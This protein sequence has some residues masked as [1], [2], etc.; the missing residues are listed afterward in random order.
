MTTTTGDREQSRDDTAVARVVADL[1]PLTATRK[2][3][4]AVLLTGALAASGRA[5]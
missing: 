2:A 5:S 4:I 3:Q 1:P